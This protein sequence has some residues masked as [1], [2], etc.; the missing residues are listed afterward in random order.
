[1]IINEVSIPGLKKASTTETSSG[2]DEF[3]QTAAIAI[4]KHTSGLTV[5]EE[6]DMARLAE[7]EVLADPDSLDLF[8]KENS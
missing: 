3:N 8:I 2:E 6:L 1:M 5:V 4:I 7:E